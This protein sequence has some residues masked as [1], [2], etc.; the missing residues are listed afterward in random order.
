MR[1]DVFQYDIVTNVNL[2][3]L[4]PKKWGINLPFNYGVGEETI[5]PKFHWFY[6]D[7]QLDQLL[8]IPTNDAVERANIE[9]RAIDYTKRTSLNF[10]G[11]RKEKNPEKKIT[12]L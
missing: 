1:E 7:I 6:Q 10:I 5:T 4:L 9:N 2:G 12:F 3:K 11:V 8:D